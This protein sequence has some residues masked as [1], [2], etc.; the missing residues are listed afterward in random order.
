MNNQRCLGFD[1]GTKRIGIAFGQTLTASARPLT[2]LRSRN[3]TPDWDG[4]AKLIDEWQP[5]RLIV[6]LPLNMDGSESDLSK[7]TRAFS[8]ELE[9]RFQLPIELEDE[10]LSSIQALSEADARK[11]KAF[12]KDSA[13]ASIILE[14]WLNSRG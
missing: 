1:F 6:G 11:S 13:A 10:R 3:N 9:R 14:Q 2:A 7:R 12:D 8:R 5:Q 4:I